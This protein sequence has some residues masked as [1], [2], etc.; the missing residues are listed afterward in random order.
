MQTTSQLHS[1][2]SRS[3]LKPLQ[4]NTMSILL[5]LKQA[6]FKLVKHVIHVQLDL[7]CFHK[8]AQESKKTRQK[9]CE[10]HTYSMKQALHMKI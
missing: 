7:V 2:F 10:S 5:N 4:A 6:S 9:T 1:F 8:V 3:R